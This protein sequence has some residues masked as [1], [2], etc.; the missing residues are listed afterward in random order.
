MAQAKVVQEALIEI[1]TCDSVDDNGLTLRIIEVQCGDE[2]S[3]TYR[4]FKKLPLAIEYMGHR[5]AKT[6]FNSDRFRA[7][8]R[9]DAVA[10]LATVLHK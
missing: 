1:M 5:Y 9:T 7:Y 2:G 10:R 4:D 6:G 3:C 8:Y